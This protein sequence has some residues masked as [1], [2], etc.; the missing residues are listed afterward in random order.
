MRKA[1]Y[2]SFFL[3][4]CLASCIGTQPFG[5][6]KVTFSK[7]E[8]YYSKGKPKEIT[9]TKRIYQKKCTGC[10]E[11]IKTR[12]KQ[13]SQEGNVIYKEKIK[14]QMYKAKLIKV[15]SKSY[16]DNGKTKEKRKI[17]RGNGFI[18][19]YDENGNLISESKF[20]DGKPL[21]PADSV[22]INNNY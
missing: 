7:S 19:K 16:Y 2:F 1:K 9:R 20:K 15:K 17:V 4:I 6:R 21:N 22:S 3:F 18:K 12:K 13:Y 5:F 10:R 14:R 8:S 11:I